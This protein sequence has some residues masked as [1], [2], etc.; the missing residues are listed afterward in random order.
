MIALTELGCNTVDISLKYLLGQTKACK[1]VVCHT[2]NAR[3]KKGIA[4]HWLVC[5]FKRQMMA[6]G[7]LSI[8]KLHIKN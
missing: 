6:S 3:H 2:H 4:Y 7:G 5:C 8:R 1:R